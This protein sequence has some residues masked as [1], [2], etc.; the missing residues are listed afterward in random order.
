MLSR[1]RRAVLFAIIALGLLGPG[2]ARAFEPMMMFLFGMAR[3]IMY[4]AFLNSRKPSLQSQEPLPEVYPGTMVEPRKLR[5][6]IDESFFYLSERRRSEIFQALHDE[7]IKPE[8]AAVRASMI[9]YFAEHAVAVR[10]V[11][12]RLSKL[13]E[14][15][16]RQ[17]SEQFVAQA[18]TLPEAEREQLRKVLG[19]GLL[20]V[21]PDLNQRLVVAMRS[22]PRAPAAEVSGQPTVEDVA[23]RDPARVRPKPGTASQ[24]IAATTREK[25]APPAQVEAVPPPAPAAS[26]APPT[27][28]GRVAPTTSAPAVW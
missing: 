10:R 6:L 22:I 9:A 26:A 16:M 15:E 20:P 5:E 27:P 25:A 11:M 14:N 3:E 24:P 17:V 13:N 18:R 4:E 12:D 28:R 19:E 21:P 2:T 8:N 1:L 7:I 23:P